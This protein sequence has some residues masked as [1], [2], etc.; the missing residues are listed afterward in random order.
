MQDGP[1]LMQYNNSIIAYKYTLRY[2]RPCVFM[3]S[4]VCDHCVRRT[5]M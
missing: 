2:V 3:Y 1:S 4:F 5:L